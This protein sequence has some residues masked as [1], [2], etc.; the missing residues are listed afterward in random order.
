MQELIE[1]DRLKRKGKMKVSYKNRTILLVYL[2]EK[3]YAIDDKC[4]H[5]GASLYPGKVDGDV[6]YC[7]DHALGIS[8][9]SGEVAS[10]K[11]ADFMKLDE[12]S[13]SVKTYSIEVKDGKVHVK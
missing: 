1:L 12:Y 8:L 13:R 4:P 9:K 7:K 2:D 6:I 5:M 11:Q 3:V 10:V